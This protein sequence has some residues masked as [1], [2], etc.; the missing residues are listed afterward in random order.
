MDKQVQ[1][2]IEKISIILQ[3]PSGGENAI[4]PTQD[5]IAQLQK[6]EN[7]GQAMLL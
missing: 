6:A 7:I 2:Y 3:N 5:Q 4:T 1:D